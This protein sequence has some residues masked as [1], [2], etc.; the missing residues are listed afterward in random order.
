MQ[1]TRDVFTSLFSP[2]T[3]QDTD[4]SR[5]EPATTLPTPNCNVRVVIGP[6]DLLSVINSISHFISPVLLCYSH[7]T[8]HTHTCTCGVNSCT[9]VYTCTCNTCTQNTCTHEI[10]VSKY[11]RSHKITWEHHS[12]TLRDLDREGINV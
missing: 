3:I 7:T 5:E 4:F 11:V 12:N 10:S 1:M 8:S 2:T 9:F 6:L